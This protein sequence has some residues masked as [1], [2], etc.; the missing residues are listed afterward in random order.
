MLDKITRE[1][2]EGDGRK[3]GS[4]LW[5]GQLRARPGRSVWANQENGVG[6]GGSGVTVGFGQTV[7]RADGGRSWITEPRRDGL[8]PGG[9]S[10]KLEN[11]G[12]AQRLLGELSFYK[13]QVNLKPDWGATEVPEG[14]GES[15]IGGDGKG[16]QAFSGQTTFSEGQVQRTGVA[17]VRRRRHVLFS[18]EPGG[19]HWLGQGV[20]W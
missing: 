20:F 1:R 3:S 15:G 10:G 13:A 2:M 7:S 12:A 18:L 8:F 5:G 14:V 4:S 16:L 6:S 19:A 17:M 11:D 9:L